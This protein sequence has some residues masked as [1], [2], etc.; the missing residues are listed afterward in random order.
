[1]N[2]TLGN[3]ISNNTFY[4]LDQSAITY[5]ANSTISQNSIT[6]T[7]TIGGMNCAAIKNNNALPAGVA[8]TST[9][10]QN[11]ITNVGNGTIGNHGILFSNANTLMLSNN[12][13]RN[14]G[15]TI[16][17]IDA[18]GVTISNN[19]LLFAR[20]NSLSVV[21]N[22]PGSVTGIVFNGNTLL[23]RNI[24][25]PYIEMRDEVPGTGK[26]S[27]ISANGNN[28]ITLYKPDAPYV[29]SVKF[30]GE[31]VDYATKVSLIMF[32]ASSTTFQSF[33]YKPYTNTGSYAT[34]NLLSNPDFEVDVTGWTPS[35]SGGLVPLLSRQVTGSYS[36]AS[37][38]V[39]PQDVLPDTMRVTNDAL[40]SITSGQF[41]EVS[42]FLRSTATGN[43]NIRAFLHQAGNF[44]NVYSD[45]IAETYSTSTGR[46][47][48]FYISATATA[49]D[50][51]LS[52]ETSNQYIPLEIDE[53]SLRRKTVIIKNTNVNEV[54]VFSNTGSSPL[55]Q[56][57][58]GGVPCAQYV[59]I[60]N[61]NIGWP[62]SSLSIA[63]F[64]TNL[65][66]W[67]NSSNLMSVPV[68]SM[69]IDSGSIPSG[70][71]AHILWNI[72]ASNT[73]SIQ[74]T[75][76]TG[77]FTIPISN[78]GSLYFEPPAGATTTTRI[79]T[80][81]DIGPRLNQVD[82]TTTNTPPIVYPVTISGI[83]DSPQIDGTLS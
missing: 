16:S 27:L 44:S 53:V 55:N 43:V 73:S 80:E 56:G 37:M 71:L 58:P 65:A 39:T 24:N 15:N 14:A 68:V 78:T 31:S 38:I 5:S 8:L 25:S 3:T 20:K 64:T 50:A 18:T 59:D 62:A 33:G 82:V 13:V 35:A 12:T 1:M 22:T 81:N 46:A 45:R 70:T 32:D 77:T 28:F 26:A 34:A 49:A 47:F 72:S 40:I 2:S 10:T 54:L 11:T 48:S 57:C 66:L 23:Q 83:E 74:Y 79:Y 17:I 41:Y 30:G 29:R 52:L 69:N 76:S 4:N 67:N 36:G 63:G 75:T 42:G 51:E 9:I 61:A 60:S 7:C 21:Q 6:N 19:T